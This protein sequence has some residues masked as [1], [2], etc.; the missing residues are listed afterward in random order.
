MKALVIVVLC[1]LSVC[2]ST[3]F[4]PQAE[5]QSHTRL[6]VINYADSS[7]NAHLTTSN[8]E[9]RD[10]LLNLYYYWYDGDSIHASLGGFAGNLLHGLYT[11]YDPGK[12]LIEEGTF[13]NGLKSG[14][15]KRWYPNGRYQEVTQWKDGVIHGNKV[16]YYADGSV[17][18]SDHYKNGKKHGTS[19][20]FL[21]DTVII[22]H[23]RNDKEIV[24]KSGM[25]KD[26]EG[27]LE[28][29]NATDP[30]GI[31]QN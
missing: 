6:I 31:T 8:P 25:E 7:I 30:S 29:G 3:V 13:N 2:C 26:T 10:N 20:C 5:S 9:N 12:N 15:W 1:S 4:I 22:N 24:R 21:N 19:Y 18:M 27:I 14:L 17:Y 23:Y 28:N 11:V 16:A